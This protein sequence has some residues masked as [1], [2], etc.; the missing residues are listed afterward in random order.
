MSNQTTILEGYSNMEKGAYL[1]SL[2]SIATADR[3]AS[4]EEL[5]Y[6]RALIE[7]AGVTEEQSALILHAATTDVTDGDLEKFLE[8]LKTSELRFSLVSDVIAFAHADDDYSEAEQHKVKQIADYLGVN[9][10]Q[11]E[12]LSEFTDRATAQ[13]AQQAEN[14]EKLGSTDSASFL[15]SLGLGDKLKNAGINTN[16]LF[17]GALGILG[18]M[19]LGRMMGGGGRRRGGGMLGGLLGGILGGGRGFGNAAGMLGRLFKR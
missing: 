5:D 8:I 10:E 15:G 13:S 19:L 18:P 11:V 7:S 4:A 12:V 16:S 14:E 3:N 1:G 9:D 6:L 17:R 2:A